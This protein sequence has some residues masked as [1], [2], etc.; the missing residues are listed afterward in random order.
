MVWV[1]GPPLFRALQG[2]E[3]LLL[4]RSKN[5]KVF[6]LIDSR[7]S[8]AAAKVYFIQKE[9]VTLA[10]EKIQ[11]GIRELAPSHDP[12]TELLHVGGKL[13]RP[14]YASEM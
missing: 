8:Q 6:F 5:A 13:I 2:L 1:P 7:P 10:L 3:L 12:V 11:M 4:Q 9:L 14:A